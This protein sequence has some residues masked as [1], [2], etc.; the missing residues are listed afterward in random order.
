MRLWFGGL[1]ALFLISSHAAV[2]ASP[3]T[4]IVVFGDSLSDPGNLYEA[5]G[6]TDPPVPPYYEG[7]FS[8][9]PIWVDYMASQYGIDVESHA[10]GGAT[11][12]THNLANQSPGQYD[13]LQQ[14][15]QG[16]AAG[17][18]AGADPDAVY[19]IW[20]GSNDFSLL[21]PDATPDQIGLFFADAIGNLL[22]AAAT[23]YAAGA[24]NVV[25]GNVP[26]LGLT[27]QA[28][29]AGL[30]DQ[31]TLLAQSFNAELAAAVEQ[32]FAEA[33]IMDS[34]GM[35]HEIVAM[36]EDLGITNLTDACVIRGESITQCAN[37]EAYL[38][39]D[40]M[41]PTSEVHRNFAARMAALLAP[42]QV[43]E[44]VAWPLFLVI[45]PLA[46]ILWR[47]RT[48]SARP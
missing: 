46:F 45:L 33:L 24:Q 18:S 4:R 39:W 25:I 21:P 38:F 22:N 9:G 20:A 8:N 17:Q 5:S 23:L 43:S 15:I 47:R 27:P 40:I 3:V 48:G 7:R 44:P 13:G 30:S 14:Q 26:D 35:L 2:H 36:A 6:H 29:Q 32:M 10:V 41:H 19:F 28:R 31:F 12:G 37:P 16:W 1:V 11:T 42:E 34:F